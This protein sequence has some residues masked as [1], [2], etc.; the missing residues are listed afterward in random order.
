MIRPVVISCLLALHNNPATRH[1]A[2]VRLGVV[3]A[4]FTEFRYIHSGHGFQ[5]AGAGAGGG[6]GGAAALPT[7]EQ[8]A[9]ERDFRFQSSETAVLLLVRCGVWTLLHF[10]KYFETFY[11]RID[12]DC[13]VKK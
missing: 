7:A 11:D 5:V 6:G 12:N 4:P 1:W 13:V 8:A 3:V 2:K 10:K 9:E